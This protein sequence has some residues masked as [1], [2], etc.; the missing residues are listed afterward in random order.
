MRGTSDL[1][2]CFCLFTVIS[3]LDT[4][5]CAISVIF[6]SAVAPFVHGKIFRSSN[7]FF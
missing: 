6:L 5:S 4:A 7:S 2:D 1:T 3:T